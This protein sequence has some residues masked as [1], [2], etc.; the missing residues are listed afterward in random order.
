MSGRTGGGVRPGRGWSRWLDR[1]GPRL[2]MTYV[3]LIALAGLV[4]GGAVYIGVRDV[5]L[6][7]VVKNLARTARV[8]GSETTSASDPLA[9][10]TIAREVAELTGARVTLVAHD[11]TVLADT[12]ADPA[13]ME[14]HGG[15]PEVR[16]ARAG[17]TGVDVRRSE[18]TGV[19]FLYVAVA[20]GPDIVVRLAM[21]LAVVDAAIARLRLMA[22]LPLAAACLVGAGLALRSARRITDPVRQLSEVARDMAAGNLELRAPLEGPAEVVELA[23]ALNLLAERLQAHVGELAAAKER[24]ESLVAG[25]PVGVVEVGRDHAVVTANPAAERLL[26]FRAGEARGRHYSVVLSSFALAQ[27][28]AGALERGESRTLEVETD[29]SPDSVVEVAVSPRRD[30]HGRAS[31]ALLVLE[32]LGPTR[33]EARVRRELVANVSHELKTPVAAIRAVAETLADGAL[34]DPEAAGRFLDHIRRESERLAK[35]VDDLL[36][37]T[38]LEAGVEPLE[39]A[40]VD[41]RAVAARA[42]E[43]FRPLAEK[44]RL[45]LGLAEGPRLEVAGDEKYLERAVANLL[46]NAIKFT[47]EN[48][49]V[50]VIVRREEAGAAGPEAVVEVRDSGAGLPPE[51]VSRVFER[52]YRADADRSRQAGGTGLGLAIVKHVVLAHGGRVGVFSAGPGLG[53]RFWFSV[54]LISAQTLTHP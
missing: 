28:I 7:L 48:G 31:G 43:R 40:S 45:R 35:L 27:A 49:E 16:A 47:P 36:E 24:L 20:S 18:T 51:A 52:F 26:S 23:A 5:Y 11:G 9:L 53:C 2:A 37:L 1:F 46:D 38:R 33:R 50:S 32:D 25:L 4:V 10:T 3:T 21:P 42:V 8:A 14:N 44:K 22:L 30:A 17:G 39:R 12:Q 6:D 54:P 29:R 19:R 13:A 15:R 41:L 34:G